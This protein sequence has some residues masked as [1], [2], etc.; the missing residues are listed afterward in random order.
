MTRQKP[1]KSE[2]KLTGFPYS[3]LWEEFGAIWES[4][5]ERREIEGK[6]EALLAECEARDGTD[7]SAPSLVKIA[8]IVDE[9][10]P[11]AGK[12][13]ELIGSL[14]R[15]AAAYWIPQLK[16]K[17]GRGAAATQKQLNQI[18][19]QAAKLA[20]LL[21]QPDYDVEVLLDYVRLKAVDPAAKRLL[22]FRALI[23]E[24]QSLSASARVCAEEVPRM[25]RGTSTSILQVR[26]M[27]ASTAAIGEAFHTNEIEVKQADS[28]GRRPRPGSKS[29]ELLF[30]Y[31]S[32]V[33][34][35]MTDTTKVRLFL[36]YSRAWISVTRKEIEADI[37][38]RKWRHRQP[39]I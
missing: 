39:R 2:G 4:L 28:A 16:R 1:P 6:Y 19:R 34:P 18:S 32:L 29:A 36:G 14:Y 17:L 21:H 8:S 5:D 38:P 31:L 15:I 3:H 20:D 7:L 30:A 10:D 35:A 9:F 37:P 24:L 27:E 33:E 26:L 12:R 23:E 11:D 22:N 13:D 25:P